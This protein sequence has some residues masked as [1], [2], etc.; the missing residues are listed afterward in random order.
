MLGRAL[1]QVVEDFSAIEFGDL[2]GPIEYRH[3]QRAIQMLMATVTQDA[4]FLQAGAHFIARETVFFWEP[5]AQ[6]AV[7]IA[8]LE[9]RDEVGMVKTA[10]L[11]IGQRFGRFFQCLVVVAG[12]LAEQGRIV[13]VVRN[14]GGQGTHAAA[15]HRAFAHIGG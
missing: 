11:Q 14:R 3:Y 2:A 6:G 13:G 8:Q 15:L 12:D 10:R 9:L 1:P 4:D 7:G 5:Q